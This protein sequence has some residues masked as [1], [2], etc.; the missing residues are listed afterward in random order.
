MYFVLL[1]KMVAAGNGNLR[2]MYLVQDPLNFGVC[3]C[4]IWR[5]FFA[6]VS[7]YQLAE[8]RLGA[9]LWHREQFEPESKHSFIAIMLLH[10]HAACF[11]YGS[12]MLVVPLSAR[13]L[14]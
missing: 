12:K 1:L 6:K 4:R 8:A 10:G 14:L 3:F 11:F 13:L 7:W 9:S 5:P 2:D